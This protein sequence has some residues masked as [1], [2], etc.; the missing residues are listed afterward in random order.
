[1]PVSTTRTLAARRFARVAIAGYPLFDMMGR[2]FRFLPDGALFTVLSGCPIIRTTRF[3]PVGSKS[4]VGEFL[5][6]CGERA[7]AKHR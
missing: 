3:S 6:N 4:Y 5:Y 2:L 1:V 7:G